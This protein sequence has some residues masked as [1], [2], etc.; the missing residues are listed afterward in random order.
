[1]RLRGNLAAIDSIAFDMGAEFG[2][3]DAPEKIDVVFTPS[4]NEWKG[5]RYL[6]LVIKALRPSI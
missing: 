5:S 6:Q 1:M 2:Q 3:M 4:V